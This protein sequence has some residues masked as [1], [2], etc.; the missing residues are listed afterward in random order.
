MWKVYNND[1]DDNNNNNDEEEDN[2]D[3]QRTNCD[4]KSSLE[5]LVQVS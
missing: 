2:E 4:Q 1:D 5:P 3:G